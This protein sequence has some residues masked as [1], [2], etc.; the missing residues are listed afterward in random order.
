MPSKTSDVNKLSVSDVVKKIFQAKVMLNE[1]L[2]TEVM[3]TWLVCTMEHLQTKMRK[4]AE[5]TLKQKK[6]DALHNQ[7]LKLGLTQKNRKFLKDGSIPTDKAHHTCPF[8]KHPWMSLPV[9]LLFLKRTW[10][11]FQSTIGKKYAL[12]EMIACAL[13]IFAQ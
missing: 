8:C 7:I 4:E 3:K 1:Y 5:D 6:E 2:Q 10:L 12:L 11:D 13:G 9:M